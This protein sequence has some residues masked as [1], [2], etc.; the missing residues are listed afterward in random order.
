MTI[1]IHPPAE[2]SP[3]AQVGEGSWIWYHAQIRETAHIGQIAKPLLGEEKKHTVLEVLSSG[4]LAQGSQVRAIE[5][6]FARMCR[7][8]FAV[9][10][11][12]ETTA[13]HVSFLA[14]GVGS[15]DE[16]ITMPFRFITSINSIH[17]TGAGLVFVDIDPETFNIDASQIEAV[18]TPQTRAILPVHVFSLSYE[19][20]PILTIAE[21]FYLKIIEDA[22]QS[23]V[24]TYK[25]RVVGSLSTGAFSF[26]PPRI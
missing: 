23:H 24:S 5:Q 7:T 3:W 19:M 12:S 15:G 20:D 22:C 1:Y 2:I 25:G 26:Y 4:M 9:A 21:N 13:L 11:S 10:T 8:T 14:N 6:A 17:Y 16:V 18:I